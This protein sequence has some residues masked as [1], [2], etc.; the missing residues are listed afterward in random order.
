MIST[1]N[2]QFIDIQTQIDECND[3]LERLYEEREKVK[4]NLFPFSSSYWKVTNLEGEVTFIKVKSWELHENGNADYV[5]G[6]VFD[7]SNEYCD[8]TGTFWIYN[9]K[10]YKVE[11]LSEKEWENSCIEA[12][13]K[14]IKK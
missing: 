8:F 9:L 7:V 13:T 3:K 6:Q 1:D 5:K 14:L 4:K 12:F 10:G 2:Q 11:Y